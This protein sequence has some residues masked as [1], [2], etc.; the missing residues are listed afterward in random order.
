MLGICKRKYDNVALVDLK[1]RSFKPLRLPAELFAMTSDNPGEEGRNETKE[2]A[3]TEPTLSGNAIMDVTAWVK[4]IHQTKGIC[5]RA[6]IVR[7]QTERRDNDDDDDNNRATS[8]VRLRTGADL[9]PIVR[10]V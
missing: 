2:N 5:Q 9:A 6:Y 1:K 8:F 4:L 7:V 3:T 10:V